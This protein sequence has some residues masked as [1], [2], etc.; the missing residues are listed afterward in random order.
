MSA[1][2][3]RD[4]LKVFAPEF[5]ALPDGTLDT[6]I[7]YAEQLVSP[8]AFGASTVFAGLN[9]TAHLLTITPQTSG[10]ASASAAQGPVS[11]RTVGSVSV[12]YAI[13]VIS[14]DSVRA[15][16]SLSKYGI[17]FANLTRRKVIA[18]GVL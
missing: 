12:S 10:S 15:G 14:D 9:M 13:P 11:S 8:T 5:S 16:L 7:G 1:E 18:L 4:Q 6:F 2:W 3:T 17:V